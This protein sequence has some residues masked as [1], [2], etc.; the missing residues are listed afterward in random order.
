MIEIKFRA[1]ASD[2]IRGFNS[3]PNGTWVYGFYMDKVG[4]SVVYQFEQS[5]ADYVEYE[6]D[7]ETVGQFTGLYDKNGKEIYEGDIVKVSYDGTSI[8]WNAIVRFGTIKEVYKFLG[9]YLEPISKSPYN[10]SIA[11]WNLEIIGNI[12]DNKE[13][14]KE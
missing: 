2:E 5:R 11:L 6:V 8:K 7:R 9:Y 13:L 3:V 14:I 10:Q 12:Y 1:K 4:L